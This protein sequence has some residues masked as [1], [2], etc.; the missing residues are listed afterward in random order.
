MSAEQLDLLRPEMPAVSEIDLSW[1]ISA[2]QGRGWL[3]AADLGARSEGEK[4]VLRAIASASKARIIS[5]QQGYRL[6][7]E[8]TLPEIDRARANLLSQKIELE[9]RIAEIDRLIH[10]RRETV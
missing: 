6:G 5:G 2:L 10:R 9:R 4:R 1:M 3:T 7:L 8:A